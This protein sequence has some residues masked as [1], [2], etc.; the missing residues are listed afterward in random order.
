MNRSVPIV[1][2]SLIA[3]TLAI[4]LSNAGTIAPTDATTGASIFVD[5]GRTTDSS[6]TL[7]WHES[8]V[9]GKLRL[10]W[11]TL[12]ILT[13][14]V[15]AI[16]SLEWLFLPGQ[17]KTVRPQTATFPGPGKARL[18]PGRTYWY[19]LQG[20]YPYPD[21][22]TAEL[23]P[24]PSMAP[25]TGYS[26]HGSFLNSGTASIQ[27]R[28][29]PPPMPAGFIRRDADGRI[30]ARN[31]PLVGFGPDGGRVQPRTATSP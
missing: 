30:Q 12:P 6:A 31:A 20:F 1:L 18:K 15:H 24:W 8:R 29:F 5:S 13:F 2:S 9:N 19:F 16:D 22:T 28:A 4:S 14:P 17:V 27:P 21:H 10:Y 7:Y 11:D 26:N 3:A 25:V 23:P